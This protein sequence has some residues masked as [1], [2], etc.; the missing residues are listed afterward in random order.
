[1]STTLKVPVR[2]IVKLLVT[3]EYER[4]AQITGGKRLDAASIE[5]AIREYGRTLIMPPDSAFDEMD[6]V[7]IENA[8]TPCWSVRMS[9]WT[10]EENRSDLSIELRLTEAEGRITIELDDIHVL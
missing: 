10:A 1:M 6:V 7:A 5:G 8:R 4:V 2:Q 9:F 3:G